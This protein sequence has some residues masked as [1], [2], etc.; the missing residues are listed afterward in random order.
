MQVMVKTYI[1]VNCKIAG[2]GLL[3]WSLVFGTMAVFDA[4]FEL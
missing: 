4:Y 1:F 2:G 3:Y